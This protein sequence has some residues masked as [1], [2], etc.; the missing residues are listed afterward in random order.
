M[1]VRCAGDGGGGGSDDAAAPLSRDAVRDFRARLVAMEAASLD[2]R[3]TSATAPNTPPAKAP[4]SWAYE[5]PLLEQG[6][7]VLG[8]LPDAAQRGFGL[9]QQ[10]FHKCIILALDHDTTFTKG[11]ILNRPTGYVLEGFS[12]WCGG[13]VQTGGLYGSRVPLPADSQASLQAIPPARMGPDAYADAA[14]G[15]GEDALAA[16]LRD[17]AAPTDGASPA[18]IT[19][20]HTLT[21]PTA[22]ERSKPVLKDL[23]RTTFA[24]AKWLVANDYASHDDFW[25]FVG[26]AGWGPGQLQ[27]ELDRGSWYL[28]AVDPTVLLGELTGM[29][30]DPMAIPR[31]D[32]EGKLCAGGDGI[33]AWE[34][35]LTRIGRQDGTSGTRDASAGFSDPVQFSD[36]MLREWV[37]SRLVPLPPI[38]AANAMAACRQTTPFPLMPGTLLAVTTPIAL[39][40]QFLH[41]SLLLVLDVRP[42]V[43]ITV[44]LN[45]PTGSV[46]EFEMTVQ[47]DGEDESGDS[48][49]L[50]ARRRVFFG[51]NLTASGSGLLLLHPSRLGC[52]V[53]I[54]GSQGDRDPPPS[55][56]GEYAPLPEPAMFAQPPPHPGLMIAGVDFNGTADDLL[57]FHGL[58]AF[59][60]GRLH[61][62][63]RMGH[64][65]QVDPSH[66]DVE[67][68]LSLG[69]PEAG[70]SPDLNERIQEMQAKSSK[71]DAATALLASN[72]QRRVSDAAETVWRRACE[73]A[74]LD[75][76]GCVVPF[77]SRAVADAALL[78]WVSTFAAE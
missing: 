43:V 68:L 66:I 54:E 8:S 48:K 41:K 62:A 35:L 10:Y 25:V 47:R 20:L 6:S 75:A 24:D 69:S 60:H 14:A 78:E 1:V 27:S 49:T 26:Y 70:A 46:L 36:C 52:G 76:T 67:T 12:V 9:G 5:T 44:V 40:S 65:S 73:A 39:D 29:R 61:R 57:V 72:R 16:L 31:T 37:R 21:D 11:I 33:G 50:T 28:A 13:D 3:S 34:R 42:N 22:R 2:E 45:R 71:D 53:R 4:A 51:G 58:T 30:L 59:P 56:S 17:S 32:D 15:D 18:D 38:A 64:I 19:V 77:S 23:C 7:V 55:R 74:A 63:I